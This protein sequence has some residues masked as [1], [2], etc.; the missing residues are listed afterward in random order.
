MFWP[1]ESCVAA[2]GPKGLGMAPCQAA[3]LRAFIMHIRHPQNSASLRPE[4][5][6]RLPGCFLTFL[7]EW[8]HPPALPDSRFAC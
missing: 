5:A 2:S 7:R 6:T 3:V 4:A 1:R 8:G